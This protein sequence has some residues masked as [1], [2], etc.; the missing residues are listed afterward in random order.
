[1]EIERDWYGVHWRLLRSNLIRL[2]VREAQPFF[3]ALQSESDEIEQVSMAFVEQVIAN[4]SKRVPHDQLG[5]WQNAL[6]LLANTA[7]FADCVARDV[8]A[9]RGQMK[10][11][12]RQVTS[13]QALGQLLWHFL[14]QSRREFVAM[15]KGVTA[16]RI[17]R[18][19]RLDRV[20]REVAA[21][22]PI[23]DSRCTDEHF[24]A[25]AVFVKTHHP[26]DRNLPRKPSTIRQ[27]FLEFSD[28]CH[29][30]GVD[31]TICLPN[32]LAAEAWAQAAPGQE[33]DIW[34]ALGTL[35]AMDRAILDIE[36]DTTL[37]D[38]RYMSKESFMREHQL[39]TATYEAHLQDVL[40]RVL[41]LVQHIA[42]GK[43]DG[44]E[45]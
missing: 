10:R 3:D 8:D 15:E 31:D 32:E 19:E 27:Y 9:L 13:K 39:D 16:D 12:G 24:A 18:W 28:T 30:L 44:G 4:I 43:W 33:T 40:D 2:C 20:S 14:E 36:C 11:K 37:G 41:P 7:R 5:L 42:R 35:S 45:Q 29:E 21:Q 17:K 26:D 38:V 25:V 22:P 6:P 23:T 1:M 34:E